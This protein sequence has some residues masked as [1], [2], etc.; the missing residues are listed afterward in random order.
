MSAKNPSDPAEPGVLFLTTTGRNSGL[1]REIEIWFV[2]SSDKLYILAEHFYATQWVKN[3]QSNPRV[4][5]VVG[6]REF[7]A[8]ARILD[9]KNDRETWELARALEAKKYGWGDGLP[10]EI[11]P[12]E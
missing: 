9:E 1:P 11:V 10:V 5:V 4:R 12:D 2:A 6:D 3:I 7:Q 8:T